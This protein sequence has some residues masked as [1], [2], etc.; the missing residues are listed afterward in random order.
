MSPGSAGRSIRVVIDDAGSCKE[1]DDAVSACIAAGSVDGFSILG[2]APGAAR[3]C[4]MA[5]DLGF[6]AGVHLNA[7]EAPL[8]TMAPVTCAGVLA[9][10]RRV[11]E[12]V[13]RE[14]RAQIEL[15]A[16]HGVPVRWLDSHR[17][18]HH[19]PGLA[20]LI[21][22][23][24]LEYGAG[25]VRAAVLPDRFA[26][27]SGPFLD[28]LGRRFAGMARGAGL[29]VPRCMAGFGVS[30]RI[31]REYLERLALPAGECELVAHPATAPVWSDGQPGE[32]A[33]LCSEWFRTWKTGI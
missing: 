22:R 20:G 12:A 29:T 7:V 13:E 17:H 23:L 30:G 3:A 27:P 31:G 14:W 5:L 16:S 28:L 21:V 9:G 26:R 6:P 18:V 8:L 4:R 19:L 25:R 24:A 33:L 2:S 11:V 10:G 15:T 32:L 1:V